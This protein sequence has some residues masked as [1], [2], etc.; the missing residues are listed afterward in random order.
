MKS[1]SIFSNFISQLIIFPI[2]RSSG[3]GFG[4][5]S[6]FSRH[7]KYIDIPELYIYSVLLNYYIFICLLKMFSDVLYSSLNL[8][9]SFVLDFWDYFRCLDEFQAVKKILVFFIFGKILRK[10][11]IWE[12]FG[13]KIFWENFGKTSGSYIFHM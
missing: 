10:M 3:D 7:E 5:K 12:I 11:K 9:L 8:K 2:C 13:K 6:H 1:F 4:Y